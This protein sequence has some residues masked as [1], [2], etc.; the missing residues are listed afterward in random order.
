MTEAT[1]K[2][3]DTTPP[4]D[5]DPPPG[6]AIVRPLRHVRAARERYLQRFSDPAQAAASRSARAWAWALGETT[7]APVT[8]QAT[9][10]PPTR[11][12]IQAE[13]AVADGRHLRDEEHDRA[14]AAATILRW[15][16][17]DD[18]HVPVRG[19]FPG[20]LVGGFGHVVRSHTQITA[21]LSLATQGQQRATARNHD[22]N[23]DPDSRKFAR[24]DADYLGGVA[25][26]LAWINGE[27]TEAPV[28]CHQADG[29]TTRALKRE[30]VR[31][32]DVIEQARYPWM[33]ERLPP[34]RYGEGV[35]HTISWLVGDTTAP[36]VD[37]AGRGPCDPESELPDILRDAE[38]RQHSC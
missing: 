38:A 17:G 26:T 14:D 32:D 30:R 3:M 35:K 36:P 2:L 31:A 29:V 23:A 18:D 24:Q 21:T 11:R 8:D 5:D 33:A 1:M 4:G 7:T 37:P 15:L 12:D 22:L 9:A 13:I 20:E 34:P 25:A 28:S 16:I 19:D 10:A 27:R 6:T